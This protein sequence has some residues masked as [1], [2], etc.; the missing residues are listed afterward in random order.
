VRAERFAVASCERQ[1]DVDMVE[2]P[3]QVLSALEYALNH[4]GPMTRELVLELGRRIDPV[5]N[6]SGFRTTPVTFNQGVTQAAAPYEIERRIARLL[7][8]QKELTAVEFYTEF[9]TIHPF[10]DGNGRVGDILYN[11]HKGTLNDP[12]IPPDV[13][14]EG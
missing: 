1:R 12:V 8:F 9:E 13:F 2:G 14:G 10:G 6:A 11:L 3:K 5:K 4:T 7:E